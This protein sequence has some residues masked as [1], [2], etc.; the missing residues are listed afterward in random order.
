MSELDNEMPRYR[1]EAE[2]GNR[3]VGMLVV[4]FFLLV[5]AAVVLPTISLF[6]W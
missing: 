4:L 2:A 3:I 6:L 5:I 1:R